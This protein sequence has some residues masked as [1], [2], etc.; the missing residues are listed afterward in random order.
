MNY[1]AELR[2][3]VDSVKLASR[4]CS[5]VQKAMAPDVLKKKDRSP[6]T[7]ADYGSQALICRALAAAYPS[8]PVIGE[9]D[10]S[11]LNDPENADFM[12]QIRSQIEH[13]GVTADENRI[14]D[15]IDR[16]GSKTYCDR[17]WTLDPIDGTKGFV[18]KEQFA[19]SL[20]LLV[21]G[22]IVV[23]ALACPNLP[24]IDGGSAGMV[25]SAVHSEGSWCEPLDESSTRQ[26]VRVSNVAL[27]ADAAFCESVESGHSAHGKSARVK[28]RLGIA[29]DPVRL[30]S[31]AKYAVVARGEAE[32]YLRLPTRADYREKIWDHAGGVLVV[33]EAG[34]RV[35][36]IH[37]KALE[38]HHGYQLEA[39]RGVVVSNGL[40]HDAVI[41]SIASVFEE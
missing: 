2:V 29:K 27:P 13:A 21:D 15:W 22:R 9:E 12:T 18:R 34:G 31:Q 40:F 14:R 20:A 23:A 36:D 35:T 28:A 32:V 16:G 39:N 10:S 41:E 33:E 37:G 11:A 30:D 25:F 4:L 19:V 8:D 7:V 1:E 24:A 17:F 6:V 3:A 5:R 26:P 38:F